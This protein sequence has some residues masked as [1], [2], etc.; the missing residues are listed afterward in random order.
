MRNESIAYIMLATV[1]WLWAAYYFRYQPF[2]GANGVA[3]WDRLT[4]QMCMIAPLWQTVPPEPYY[5]QRDM[6][7]GLTDK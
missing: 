3:I 5:C 7:K 4:G 2:V 1:V 6:L